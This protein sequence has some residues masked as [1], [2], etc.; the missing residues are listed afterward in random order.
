MPWMKLVP[1]ISGVCSIVGT[2]EMSRKPDEHREREDENAKRERL[3]GAHV[4]APWS[5]ASICSPI[6]LPS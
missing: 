1:D 5:S 2:L 6:G 4:V 3:S